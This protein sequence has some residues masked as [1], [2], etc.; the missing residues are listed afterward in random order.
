MIFRDNG[1]VVNLGRR[2]TYVRPCRTQAYSFSAVNGLFSVSK[3]Y[4]LRAPPALNWARLRTT[5]SG[6]EATP[7][8][9]TNTRDVLGGKGNM[10]LAQLGKV[11]FYLHKKLV[12]YM[13]QR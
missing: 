8:G 12:C 6:A 3:E 11:R 4:N 10:T 5:A 2:R 7:M 13:S 1:D 9:Q